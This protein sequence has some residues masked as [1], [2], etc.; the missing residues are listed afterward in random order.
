MVFTIIKI[1]LRAILDFFK[2]WFR[3][4]VLLSK[5]AIVF[6]SYIG[7]W[8]Y[9]FSKNLLAICKSALNVRYKHILFSAIRYPP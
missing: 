4:L 5:V 1:M 3:I 7:R 8:V 2:R 6:L 9:T